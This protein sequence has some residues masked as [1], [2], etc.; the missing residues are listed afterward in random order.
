[1]VKLRRR[2]NRAVV[3]AQA[4]AAAGHAEAE[5]IETE[6]HGSFADVEESGEVGRA[7]DALPPVTLDDALWHQGAGGE[8]VGDALPLL[9]A[10][11]LESDST[12]RFGNVLRRLRSQ[13]DLSQ[14]DVANI[15]GFSQPAVSNWEIG[16]TFPSMPLMIW[17]GLAPLLD[18]EDPLRRELR[19]SLGINDGD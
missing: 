15:T 5:L 19:L 1:V 2:R 4:V 18:V 8:E 17:D 11:E 14:Q 13:L 16:Y 10:L 7:V 12:Q 3:G 6:S 9:A